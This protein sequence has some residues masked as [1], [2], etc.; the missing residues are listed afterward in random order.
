MRS[1][2]IITAPKS[3]KLTVSVPETLVREMT[4][5]VNHE[6]ETEPEP[7]LDLRSI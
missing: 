5:E 6:L 2:P 1:K 4:A 7:E 3:K